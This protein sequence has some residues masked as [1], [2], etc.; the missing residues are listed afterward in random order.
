MPVYE[1]VGSILISVSVSMP[2]TT[3]G[4][5]K[6]EQSVMPISFEY[7]E[8]DRGTAAE[9]QQINRD[10]L[11]SEQVDAIALYLLQTGQASI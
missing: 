7:D 11:S 8:C 5:R 6:I 3:E 9:W 4:P 10:A 2:I 1:T